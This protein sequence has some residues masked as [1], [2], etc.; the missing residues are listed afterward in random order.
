MNQGC[1][2]FET[3]MASDLEYFRGGEAKSCLPRGDISKWHLE[4]I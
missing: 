4:E 1:H 3:C 2:V